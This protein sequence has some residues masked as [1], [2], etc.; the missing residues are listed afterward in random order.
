MSYS[1]ISRSIRPCSS[2]HASNSANVAAGEA[3]GSGS[4][5]LISGKAERN[6][7]ASSS[8]EEEKAISMATCS[9]GL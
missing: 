5:A 3:G 4:L 6:W 2:H 1:S 9:C 7:M 8:S